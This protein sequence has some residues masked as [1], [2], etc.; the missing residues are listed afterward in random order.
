LGVELL[1]GLGAGFFSLKPIPF[2]FVGCTLLGWG[3]GLL[4]GVFPD[5]RK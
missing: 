2:F 3:L 5:K 1:I 4:L